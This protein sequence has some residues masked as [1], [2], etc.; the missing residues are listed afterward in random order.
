MKIHD[1]MLGTS[2]P[3]KDLF[4]VVLHVDEE[5]KVCTIKTKQYDK[6]FEYSFDQLKE[7]FIGVNCFL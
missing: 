6:Q 5:N 1:M 2:G 7:E 4:A 3:L